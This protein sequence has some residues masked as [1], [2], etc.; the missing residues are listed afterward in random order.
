MFVIMRDDTYLMT[1]GT[2]DS[3]IET[4]RLYG[5]NKLAERIAKKLKA[6]VIPIEFLLR[7]KVWLLDKSCQ[8]QSSRALKRAVKYVA[9]WPEW[10]QH[11]FE[12]SASSTR[13]PVINE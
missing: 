13:K 4:V 9:T 6:E 11:T 5:N 1:N 12:N 8:F 10:K 7:N 2:F 3:K